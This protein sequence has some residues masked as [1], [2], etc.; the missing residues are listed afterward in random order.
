MKQHI[1]CSPHPVHMHIFKPHIKFNNYTI[2]K[3]G[4]SIK[5]QEA[6]KNVGKVDNELY[7]PEVVSILHDL[8]K[9]APQPKDI[10]VNEKY[11][12]I[13]PI[14]QELIRMKSE[15]IK[16]ADVKLGE[17]PDPYTTGANDCIDKIIKFITNTNGTI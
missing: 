10:H 5:Q 3:K 12:Q 14:V 17:V 13:N 15:Y 8:I 6:T 1:V 2:I 16:I 11:H 9:N 4:K 7:Q